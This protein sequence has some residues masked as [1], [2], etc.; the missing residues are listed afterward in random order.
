MN[1][2]Y[3][4]KGLWLLSSLFAVGLTCCSDDETESAVTIYYATVS[5]I[6]PSMFYTTAA[7]TYKGATPSAFA[8]EGITLD[9][10]AFTDQ[11][12]CFSINEGSGA[13]SIADTEALLPGLYSLSI[14]CQAGGHPNYF[15]DILQIRML[16]ATPENISVTPETLE[17]EYEKLRDD[18]L[19]SAQIETLDESVTISKYDLEQEQGKEYFAVSREGEISVNKLFTGDILPGIYTPALVLTSQA[20]TARYEN[21]VTI[22]VT[23]KPLDVIFERNPGRAEAQ[24]VFTGSTPELKGSP[25]EVVYSIVSV[26]P[27]TDQFSIDPATGVVSAAAGNTLRVGETHVFTLKIA[28]KYGQTE[29]PE[30]YSVEVVDFIEPIQPA[31]F[32]YAPVTLTEACAL[33]VEKADGFVGDDAEFTLGELAPA[34]AGQLSIDQNTGAISFAKGNKIPASGTPYAIPVIA[35]NPKSDPANPTTATLELTV[36]S[37]PNMFRKFGYGNN[38]GLDAESNADQFAYEVGEDASDLKVTIPV[39]YE[40]FPEGLPVKFEVEA[41]HAWSFRSP[42]VDENTGVL[43]LAVRRDARAGQVGY[44]RVTATVG[45]GETAV[46]RSTLVFVTAKPKDNRLYYKPFVHR[47]NPR[48]G[49]LSGIPAQI[50]PAVDMNKLK[51]AFKGLPYYLDFLAPGRGPVR[52]DSGST[53][54]D[55][56]YR[57]WKLYSDNTGRPDVNKSSNDPFT[58]YAPSGAPAADLAQKLGYIDPTNGYQMYIAPGMWMLDGVPANGIFTFQVRYSD[59]NNAIGDVNSSSKGSVVGGCIW[60]DENF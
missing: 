1:K 50:D 42:T 58:Y 60:L 40:D 2:K 41:T 28:N 21:R 22:K 57:M 15:A 11:K 6:G 45:E 38:L 37:N 9:G 16:P 19:P 59:G 56:I 33:T 4:I 30:I 39:G 29:F 26:A 54:E 44:C 5:D 18:E 17:I 3:F 31:T 23:S 51:V 8:I 47:I 20:G 49:G 35:T 48:T 10:K 13:V 55:Y 34:L 12:P 53:T 46:S 14:S 36:A 27:Q 43:A 25:E 32:K 24:Y 52:L 7:P